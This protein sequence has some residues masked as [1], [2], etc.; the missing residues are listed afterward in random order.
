MHKRPVRRSR[1]SCIQVSQREVRVVAVHQRHV[2][3]LDGH[4]LNV[5]VQQAVGETQLFHRGL[6]R[7][8]NQVAD[9]L[10]VVARHLHLAVFAGIFQDDLWLRSQLFVQQIRGLGGFSNW[11]VPGAHVPS[12]FGAAA[13]PDE[14]VVHLLHSVEHAVCDAALGAARRVADEEHARPDVHVLGLHGRASHLLPGLQQEFGG[15]RGRDAL[16]DHSVHVDALLVRH[17]EVEVRRGHAQ[18][19]HLPPLLHVLHQSVGLVHVWVERPI[20]REELGVVSSSVGGH[21]EARASADLVDELARLDVAGVHGRLPAVEDGQPLASE[22]AQHE[23]QDAHFHP[24]GDAPPH[25][26]PDLRHFVDDQH[27]PWLRHGL[28]RGA[29][30]QPDV[31]QSPPSCDAG[32]AVAHGSDQQLG[33]VRLPLQQLQPHG[34]QKPVQRVRLAHAGRTA[35]LQASVVQEGLCEGGVV[36][37][38]SVQ[39]EVCFDVHL[40]LR[41]GHVRHEA[42]EEAPVAPLPRGHLAGRLML[43]LEAAA[44]AVELQGVQDLLLKH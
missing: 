27:G 41:L 15:H 39:A 34:L 2:A 1:D 19:I 6:V 28:W 33:I 3:V 29:V 25:V 8:A 37:R 11:G 16:V 14:L 42:F 5:A 24:A 21:F 13:D 35:D 36:W 12:V 17:H 22:V 31:L 26:H 18:R 44:A 30:L 23:H 7:H 20:P 10:L 43:D 38:I 9:A 4:A 40:P 32:R